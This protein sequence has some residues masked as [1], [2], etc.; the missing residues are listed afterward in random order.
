MYARLIGVAGVVLMLAA[1]SSTPPSPGAGGGPRTR[2][3]G[4]T[5]RRRLR[6]ARSRTSRQAPATACS[7]LSTASDIS[8]EAQQILAA[9]GRLAAAV[10]KRHGHDRGPL[11]RARH[12][13]IQ[14]GAR[15][16]PR[17]GGQERAGGAGHPGRPRSRR[18]ATA[19]SGRRSSGPTTRPMPRTAAP[20][21]PST[22]GRAPSTGARAPTAARRPLFA[23]NA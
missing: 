1:C 10:P 11:R 9:P 4:G 7:S 13:R 21:P 15:R 16:A 5:A 23:Q 8:P 2:G 22:E 19:R 3:P 20:S 12:A 18:S 6:R 14:S 17:P